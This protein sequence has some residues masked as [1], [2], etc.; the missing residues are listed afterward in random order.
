MSLLAYW[1]AEM[2]RMSDYDIR[3]KPKAWA[4]SLDE[5]SRHSVLTKK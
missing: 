1:V 4:G 5:C 3:P 2:G